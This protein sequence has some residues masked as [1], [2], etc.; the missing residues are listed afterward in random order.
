MKLF[1]APGTCSLSPLIVAYEVGIEPELVAVDL[2]TTPHR[3]AAGTDFTDI[4]PN[5]YVPALQLDDGSVLTE[6]VAIVEYLADLKPG[7]GLAPAPGSRERVAL[8]SWLVFIATELHKTF[9]PWLFHPEVGEA[10][11]AYARERIS[12]RLAD[13][14]R[15]LA[16]AGPFL[17]GRQF[18]VADA[19][20]FAIVGWSRHA[21]IDLEPFPALRTW[22]Q[23]IGERPAVRA[24][25]RAESAER[26]GNG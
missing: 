18:T 5:G 2:A 15:R 14:D 20:L 23:T 10:A 13:V 12:Q 8:R 19:Y 7:S 4:N 16:S 26:R 24:A 1:H 21:G 6:G 11:Q 22:Q 3:T 17:L 9:S 25:Q